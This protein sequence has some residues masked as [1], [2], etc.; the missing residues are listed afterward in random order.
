MAT[1]L[2]R[3]FIVVVFLAG[4]VAV[5]LIGIFAGNNSD[6]TPNLRPATYNDHPTWERYT[7]IRG[8]SRAGADGVRAADIDGDGLFDLISGWEESGHVSVC[9]QPT[10]VEERTRR[11]RCDVMSVRGHPE[12]ACPLRV[13]AGNSWLIAVA[14]D[15]GG[16]PYLLNHTSTVITQ[17]LT[18]GGPQRWLQF[19]GWPSNEQVQRIY[20]G[21]AHQSSYLA[22]LGFVQWP[23]NDFFYAVEPD[24]SWM[25]SI[26]T[27]DV[28]GDGGVDVVF[29]DRVLGTRWLKD[30]LP[31]SQPIGTLF[32][33]GRGTRFIEHHEG[34]FVEACAIERQL[35]LHRL[36]EP[37]V[38]LDVPD[39][40]GGP[41]GP[42]FGDFNNDGHVDIACS[43]FDDFGPR[44]GLMWR[45]GLTGR[46]HDI[47][48]T[49]GVKWDVVL[50]LDVDQDG[51]TDV[52]T[53]E[54]ISNF[55]VVWFRNPL[56]D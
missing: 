48:G 35:L 20:M 53:T 2:E 25:M 44:D 24:A 31:P 13:G 52:I 30:G 7:V 46:W 17:M 9:Y 15:T 21:G 12:D 33:T 38:R 41:K 36:G 26:L 47:A 23:Q 14:P 55:G 49:Q 56:G 1:Q 50:A 11:W 34:L 4:L 18:T 29:S 42:V 10:L 16:G 39:V 5:L 51:F 45:D 19:A 6:N 3:L 22:P 54:E 43:F 8:S 32:C 40:A 28:D 37:S 27:V